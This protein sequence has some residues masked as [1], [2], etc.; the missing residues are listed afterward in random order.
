MTTGRRIALSLHFCPQGAAGNAGADQ[1]KPVP[2]RFPAQGNKGLS[3][4][5]ENPSGIAPANLCAPVFRGSDRIL[6]RD[7]V[8]HVEWLPARLNVVDFYYAFREGNQP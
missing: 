1:N 8:S 2:N 4:D 6:W 5:P 3:F 7:A